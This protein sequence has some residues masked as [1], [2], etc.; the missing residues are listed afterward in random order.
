MRELE[1]LYINLAQIQ[2]TLPVLTAQSGEK[3]SDWLAELNVSQMNE[4]IGGDGRKIRPIYSKP[5]AIEKGFETPNLKVK[6]NYHESINVKAAGER[7][8]FFS[9]DSD[10]D[11]IDFLEEHYD[12]KQYG[13][14][15]KNE[16]KAVDEIEPY[17][18]K[19]L[20]KQLEKG[21]L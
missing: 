1:K 9:N 18:F 19:D 13:I 11:K 5:Y 16:Q 7:M 6:G 3:N 12:N 4:G 21:I 15:P 14:A 8:L 2:R 20:E 10:T 17:L